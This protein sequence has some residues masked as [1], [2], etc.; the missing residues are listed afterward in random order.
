MAEEQP[1]EIQTEQQEGNKS[2][3]RQKARTLSPTE[4]YAFKGFIEEFLGKNIGNIDKKETAIAEMMKLMPD[5]SEP[6]L[7]RLYRQAEHNFYQKLPRIPQEA[8]INKITE[9]NEILKE[10]ILSDSNRD[11]THQAH[12]IKELDELNA[13][14]HRIADAPAQVTI[15]IETNLDENELMQEIVDVDGLE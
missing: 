5:V 6:H 2:L 11:I 4:K 7:R 15:K 13:R 1:T 10:K 12:A 3:Q 8:L 14:I 9:Q